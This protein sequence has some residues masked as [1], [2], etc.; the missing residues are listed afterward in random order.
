MILDYYSYVNE[1]IENNYEVII[2][3]FKDLIGQEMTDDIK[4]QLKQYETEIGLKLLHK[5]IKHIYYKTKKIINIMPLSVKF[6]VIYELERD[7]L[8]RHKKGVPIYSNKIKAI[9]LELVSSTDIAMIE[10]G[11]K[12]LVKKYKR[13]TNDIDP[14]GEEEWEVTENVN[15]KDLSEE[16]YFHSFDHLRGVKSEEALPEL[17]EYEEFLEKK[18]LRKTIVYKSDNGRVYKIYPEMLGI[19]GVR[20]GTYGYKDTIENI[21]VVLVARESS[22]VFSENEKITIIK[23]NIIISEQD[24]YGEEDWEITENA[25]NS[26]IDPYGEEDWGVRKEPDLR[27]LPSRVICHYSFSVFIEGEI[28]DVSGAYGNPQRAIEEF[29][30]NDYMPLE[31]I[32]ILVLR[33]IGNNV[34]VSIDDFILYFNIVY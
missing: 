22:K 5:E 1:N 12:L 21:Q 16:F 30:I 11:E 7:W 24:P 33:V 34:G 4:Q 2:T 29:G 18:L 6:K 17:D 32:S 15:L 26:D 27:P 13:I 25:D 14:Y 8:E 28:Y 19:L 9:D 31:C 23:P 10:A 3:P 20:K